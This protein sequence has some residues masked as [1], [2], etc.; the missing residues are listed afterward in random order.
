MA[1]I[2]AT[3]RAFREAV[4][5]LDD[6]QLG[7]PYRDG[8]WTVR[9]LIHHMPDSHCNAYVRF[10]LALT[11]EKPTIRPY[12][13]ALWAELPDTRDTPVEVSL[14]ML[15]ALHER[16]VALLRGMEPAQ[17]ASRLIHPDSGEWALDQF[18]TLYAWHGDHHTGHITAL[19]ERMGWR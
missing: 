8:G 17:F 6:S 2:E 5:G 4:A 13:E 19:R 18:L 3:P 9:Q 15:E 16:W 10:K 14:V 7:T 1:R 11:E 12:D